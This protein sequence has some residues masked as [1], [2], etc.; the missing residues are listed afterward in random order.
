MLT[1]REEATSPH[2]PGI[3]AQKFV[4]KEVASLS[5]LSIDMILR[6]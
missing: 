3:G 6:P 1:D 2:F 5:E 4:L